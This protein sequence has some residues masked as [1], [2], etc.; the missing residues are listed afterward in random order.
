MLQ[1]LAELHGLPKSIAVDNGS[2]FGGRALDA[3]AYQVDVKLSF[4]RSGK[5]V[6]KAYI[7]SF[8]RKFRDECLNGHWFMSLRQAKS[9]IEDWRVEHNTERPNS[10]LG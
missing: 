8:N 7:E 6:E 1:W 2:G 3:W 4:I 5:P 9:L 10:A